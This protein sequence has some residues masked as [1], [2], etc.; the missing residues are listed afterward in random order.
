MNLIGRSW[1][2]VPNESLLALAASDETVE[3]YEGCCGELCDA[4]MHRVPGAEILYVHLDTHPE[5]RYHMVPIVNGLVHCAWFPGYIL[6]PSEYVLVAF[7][8]HCNKWSITGED[9]KIRDF[10]LSLL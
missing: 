5:W 10:Y 8:G 4:V 9:L 2:G 7:F 6:P 1:S 3:D